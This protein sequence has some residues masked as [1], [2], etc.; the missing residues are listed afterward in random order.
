M[1]LQKKHL[2]LLLAVGCLVLYYYGSNHI[3]YTEYLPVI[4]GG[5]YALNFLTN[6]A[7]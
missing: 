6:L 3:P 1:E 2:L 7:K 4:G 5:A